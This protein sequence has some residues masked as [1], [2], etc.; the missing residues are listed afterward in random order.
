MKRRPLLAALAAYPMLSVPARAGVPQLKLVHGF[1]VGGNADVTARQLAEKLQGAY[2]R[3]SIVESKTGA[4]GRIA[5]EAVKLAPADGATLLLAPM[6]AMA[7]YP[8]VYKHLSYRPADD[9]AA[10]SLAATFALGLGVGPAV[11][12]TVTDIRQLLAW[13]RAHPAQAQFGSPSAGTSAHFLGVQLSQNSGVPM[14]HVPYRGSVPGVSDLIGGQIPLMV[15]ALGDFLPHLGAGKLRLIA[16]SAPQRSRFAPE[17]PTLE[18]SGFPALS[19]VEWLG[20]FAPAHT[21]RALVV[22][23]STALRSAAADPG[24]ARALATFGLEAR[25]STPAQLA[26]WLERDLARWGPIVRDSGFT[27]ES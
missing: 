18:E 22:S 11:P 3:V 2:A 25:T 14:V 6:S 26:E 15:T 19:V 12:A 10:V 16:T 1:P 7:I 4:G 20:V 9:F 23:A 21:Q 24:Y 8:H 5:A 13:M 27:A 17:V